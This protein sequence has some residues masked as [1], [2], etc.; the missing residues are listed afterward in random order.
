MEMRGIMGGFYKISEW[1]MR[2]SVTNIL[3]LICSS[4]FA[5]MLLLALV[6]AQNISQSY[7]TLILTM[8]V[9]PFTL[10]PATAAMYTV[11]RKWIMGDVDVPLFKTFFR[12]YRDNYVQSMLGGMLYAAVFII[13]AVDSHIYLKQSGL[14]LLS[15]VFIG[16]IIIISISMLN[17][18]SML[19]HYNMKTTQLL[20]NAF[21]ITIGRPIR[22]LVTAAVTFVIIYISFTKFTFLIPFFM[23]SLIAYASYW[24]FNMIYQKLVAQS[25]KDSE[26]ADNE[27][28]L[29]DEH[30]S[31]ETK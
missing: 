16:L 11:A 24:N 14:Q 15:Y 9:A 22:S 5:F 7:F 28:E 10:F 1:I 18:F 23:G 26:A 20:K 31:E 29:I 13:M 4:P 25:E 21:L 8:I 6:G 17:F 12:G 2:L 30:L 27:V 3:W 19:V